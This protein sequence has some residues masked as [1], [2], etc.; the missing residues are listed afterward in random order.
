MIKRLK[1]ISVGALI[2][3]AVI[4]YVSGHVH[5]IPISSDNSKSKKTLYSTEHKVE[6]A[7]DKPS[8]NP[9]AKMQSE[10]EKGDRIKL[11]RLLGEGLDYRQQRSNVNFDEKEFMMKLLVTEK[12]LFSSISQEFKDIDLLSSEIPHEEFYFNT[13]P[14]SLLARMGLI[15]ILKSYCR[16]E[17]DES[18]AAQSKQ[19]FLDIIEYSIPR[20]LPEHIKKILVSEKYDALSSLAQCDPAQGFKAYQ[21]LNNPL[22]KNLLLTALKDGLAK[23]EPSEDLEEIRQK[24]QTH[25]AT[26]N[27]ESSI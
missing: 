4:I 18:S 25:L 16:K 27:K 9:G 2:A 19:T 5:K 12:S 1:Y 20:N 13:K 22:L 15:D 23:S 10:T 11:T 3:L 21:S 7:S 24:L 6:M 26:S 8:F 17:I 14:R